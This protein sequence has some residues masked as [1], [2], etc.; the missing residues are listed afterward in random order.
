MNQ[1]IQILDGALYVQESQ[2]IKIDALSQ[3]QLIH[4]FITGADEMSLTAF[5]ISHQFDIEEYLEFMIKD[6]KTNSAGEVHLHID[7]LR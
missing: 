7:L 4:C 3:G 5:Y 6:E 2:S 1:L